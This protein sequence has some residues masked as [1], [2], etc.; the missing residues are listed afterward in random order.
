MT[1]RRTAATDDQAIQI[2]LEADAGTLD[3][4]KWADRLACSLE[5]IRRIARRDTHRALRAGQKIEGPHF[6]GASAL[7]TDSEPTEAEL[8]ESLRKLSEQMAYAPQ[9]SRGVNNLLDELTQQGKQD[10]QKD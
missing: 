9:T 2:R 5:T 7:P 6:R 8:T 4:R 10:A 3:V 1:A